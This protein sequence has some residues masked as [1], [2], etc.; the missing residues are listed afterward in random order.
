MSEWRACAVWFKHSQNLSLDTARSLLSC[1]QSYFN[2]MQPRL[3]ITVSLTRNF[4]L[5]FMVHAFTNL[6]NKSKKIPTA[7]YHT[8]YQRAN[9]YKLAPIGQS[10]IWIIQ[11]PSFPP[12]WC[13]YN[14]EKHI[15]EKSFLHLLFS[16][17]SKYRNP[18]PI[19][20]VNYLLC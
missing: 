9:I 20:S 14:F 18:S 12:F 4:M 10:G 15:N 19:D 2:E 7:K 13:L 1:K 11:Y 16:C 3:S 6:W 17:Y 5:Y 8:Q